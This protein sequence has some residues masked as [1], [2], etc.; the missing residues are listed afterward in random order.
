MKREKA[1]EFIYENMMANKLR[2]EDQWEIIE[3]TIHETL[4]TASRAKMEDY[5]FVIPFDILNI[6]KK[7]KDKHLKLGVNFN[8][9]EKQIYV[10]LFNADGSYGNSDGHKVS[11]DA[12]EWSDFKKP[13][14]GILA[15][16]ENNMTDEASFVNDYE[17]ESGYDPHANSQGN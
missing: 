7:D 9:N 15:R 6:T 4:P 14:L 10:S 17:R 16:I 12:Y 8:H 2:W 11:W 5:D 3:P 13:L 1:L